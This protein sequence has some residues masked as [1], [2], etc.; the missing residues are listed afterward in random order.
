MKN[1]KIANIF[2]Q[3]ANRN[4]AMA[5]MYYPEMKAAKDKSDR[6]WYAE[7]YRYWSNEAKKYRAEAEKYS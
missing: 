1:S 6:M 4:Q 2:R 7:R 5:D 3:C